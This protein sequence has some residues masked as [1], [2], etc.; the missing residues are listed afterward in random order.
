M[1]KVIFFLLHFLKQKFLKTMTF[2]RKDMQI[3]LRWIWGS[4]P[5]ALQLD[6]GH[7]TGQEK[8]GSPEKI[9]LVSLERTDLSMLSSSRKAWREKWGTPQGLTPSSSRKKSIVCS[10]SHLFSKRLRRGDLNS[11]QFWFSQLLH[12]WCLGRWCFVMGVLSSALQDV[13]QH[14]QPLYTSFQ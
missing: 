13:W 9:I 5:T 3:S 7:V 2:Q 12:Y 6:V 14:P 8:R 11:V 1:L 10:G 4:F